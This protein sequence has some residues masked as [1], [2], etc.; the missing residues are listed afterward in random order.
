[1]T[2]ILPKIRGDAYI[3]GKWGP[4]DD[5]ATFTVLNP[6]RGEPVAEV[7]AGAKHD[8]DDAVEAARRQLEGGEWSRTS[9]RDRG[10]L[11]R[12]LA[13]LVDRDREVLA[14]IEAIDVGRPI[15]EPR[16]LDLPMAVSTY[17]YFAGW[18]DKTRYGLAAT[19]WT[20]NLNLAH[21]VASSI[22]AGVIWVNGWSAIDPS[23]PWSG[24]KTS[25][26]G[27]ELGWS[28]IASFTAEKVITLVM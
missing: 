4:A 11:L 20:R 22:N 18:A 28:S 19:I 21:R 2:A 6:A 25:G 13:R 16:D 8:V 23:L 26:I 24:R 5:G 9:G 27:S 12:E 15:G 7:A 1:M 17:E 3:D 10:K 14:K